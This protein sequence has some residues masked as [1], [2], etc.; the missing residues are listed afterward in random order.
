MSA[1]G[2]FSSPLE[3]I[4]FW[5]SRAELFEKTAKEVREEFEEFQV[6]IMTIK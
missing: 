1:T 4:A 3:E 5:K 2:N 6:K